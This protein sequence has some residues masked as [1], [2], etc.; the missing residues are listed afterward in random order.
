MDINILGRPWETPTLPHIGRLR[1]RATLFPYKTEKSAL[2]LDRTKSTWVQSLN[3]KWAFSFHERVHDV[4][5]AELVDVKLNTSKWDKVD[6]PGNFTMQGYSIPHYTNVKMPFEAQIPNVP[7][8]NPTGVYRTEF[9]VPKAWLKRRTVLHFGGVESVAYVFLNGK[10]I[11]MFKDTRL[12]SEFDITKYLVEGKNVLAVMVIRWSDSSY[13]EDQDHWWQ[14]GIYRDVYLY[15]QSNDIFIE[16]VTIQAGYDY[17]T[18]AGELVVKT[19]TNFTAP[20]E[21]TKYYDIEVMLYDMEDKPIL[22][23]PLVGKGCTDYRVSENITT[24]STT[25]KKVAP[26][27]AEVPNLYKVVIT[28]KDINGKIV[29]YTSQRTGFRTIELKNRELLV[30]GCPVLIRGVNRHDHDFKLGKTVPYE[31]MLQDAILMKQFNFNAVRCCHYPNDPQWLDIC[32]EFGLYVVDEA[33]I[34]AH[35]YYNYT[36]RSEDFRLAY[37]ERGSRMVI[38][39]KNHPSII[40]WSLGNESGYGENHVE[41]ARW[42]R[43]Y[44]P[45]RLLHGEG[46]MH[47]TWHQNG[48]LFGSPIS[49]VATDVINPMYT[50]IE[51][52]IRFATEVDDDRPMILCEYSHAMGNSCGCLKDYWDAFYKYH[53]LQGGYIWDWIDQGLLK[54]DD[55]GQPF[56][57]YGGDFGDKPN[58][59][60]FCCN[61]MVQPDRL[62]KP[63]MY[64]FKKIVQPLM[65]KL[66]DAKKGIIEVK[67]MDFFRNADWLEGSWYIEIE[68]NPTTKAPVPMGHY[69]IKPQETVQIKLPG[70]DYDKLPLA[71]AE[72]EAFLVVVARTCEEQIWAPAGHEVAW[73]QFPI[74]LEV[75]EE[76]EL[77]E[78]NWDLEQPLDVKAENASTLTITSGELTLVVDK[79]EGKLASLKLGE[80]DVITSGPEFNLWRAPLDNDG[81]KGSAEQWRAHWKPL[82][83]WSNDGLNKLT[84][85]LVEFKA[86]ATKA[87]IVI[88][89]KHTY[90]PAVK[91][92]KPITVD[93]QYTIG[94]GG[95]IKCKHT[96]N[97]PEGLADPPMLGMAMATGEGFEELNW[98]GLGPIE[99]YADRKAGA[100]VSEWDNLVTNEYFPYVLPQES[101]NHEDTR[102]FTLVN[103]EGKGF[104]IQAVKKP[105]GFS[106][107]HYA[108]DDI[109]KCMHHNE[110]TLR[111]ETFVQINAIQRGL[112]TSSCGPDTL[113][114]Y[115]IKSG[116][117]VLE[118]YIL[119][120]SE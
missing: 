70:Y 7:E 115:K 101:G 32:D 69:H 25:I 18:G 27:S 119:P 17:N 3:G 90:T 66:I 63:Q 113:D 51:N 81:V 40:F 88:K 9:E 80:T 107:R 99:T 6:V 4:P 34:E 86:D 30:N 85:K 56:W 24:V 78:P 47:T 120:I 26:W 58:D 104:Q 42:I 38:R 108:V 95:L 111:K 116:K 44:D 114:K 89:T 62:P 53:G 19:K 1:A 102:W 29:E 49:H 92:D 112:G 103:E 100:L 37:L 52:C 13:I 12:P 105:F 109:T 75:S 117:Y 68:G 65:F 83:R 11:G 16:D 118:Y 94:L 57:A 39:D 2:T 43:N 35:A 55:K 28:L 59:I 22:K 21:A 8:E 31:C 72:Q 73:E 45:T 67:N 74:P 106:A 41:M 5:D 98:F 82:G 36:C 61:G 96:F 97:Y 14:A 20:P 50:S 48:G 15:S 87:G 33:N 110:L 77:P 71:A 60:D 84:K 76:L 23:K 93:S 64:E 79:K 91:K 46:P 10:R 54:Y